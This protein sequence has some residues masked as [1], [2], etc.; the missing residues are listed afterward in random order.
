[1]ASSAYPSTIVV[2]FLESLPMLKPLLAVLSSYRRPLK[3][4]SSYIIDVLLCLNCI[5]V[6]A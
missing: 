3:K 4:K 2:V 1:M 5:K 6:A